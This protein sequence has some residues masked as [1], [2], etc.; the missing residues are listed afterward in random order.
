MKPLIVS[1]HDEVA[2]LIRDQIFDG[3]LGAGAFID[4]MKLCERLSISRTPLREALKV[5]VSEGLLRHETR[6]GCF[7]REIT[8]KDIDDIFPVLGLLEGRA[9]Y[10][11]ALRLNDADVEA[12]TLWHERLG[13]LAVS[14]DIKAYY[15]TN[16]VIHES[17]IALANN[18]WLTQVIADLRRILRLSRLLQL[19][20]PE[21]LEK[22][23]CEHV[24]IFD[25][26]KAK[27]PIAAQEAMK[28]HLNQQH[29]VIR[30]LADETQQLTLELNL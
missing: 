4:E 17:I 10:E 20:M 25:A 11:A 2:D 26:L 7:V 18:A 22:S 27:N 12:L 29:L 6:V 16:W 5:L 3:E 8:R 15:K 30:R 23:F 19:Q 21:R 24:K 1:L 9:A 28:E 13:D 14:Q